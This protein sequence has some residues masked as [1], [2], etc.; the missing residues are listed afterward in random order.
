MVAARMLGG[1][2]LPGF[3]LTVALGVGFAYSSTEIPPARNPFDGEPLLRE[4]L[5]QG[6]VAVPDGQLFLQMWHYAPEP[7]KSRLL[8]L[9]DDEAALKYMGFDT[10]D[11]GI[12]VL[13]DWSSVGVVEYRNFASPGREFFVYQ[14]TARPGWVIPKV[15]A[16]GATVEV[17]KYAGFRALMRVRLKS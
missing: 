3:L 11:G 15:A 5:E 17:R 4:A 7:L 2:A 8:F 14:N 1:R 12:R 10:I 13:R 6:P 16:D 9:A